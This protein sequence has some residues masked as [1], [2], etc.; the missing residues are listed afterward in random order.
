[1]D[2][3]SLEQK[4]AFLRAPDSYPERP[5]QVDAIETHMS[6]LFLTER[7]VFKLKKPI[8]YDRLDFTTLRLRRFYCEEEVRLNRRLAGTVYRGALPLTCEGDGTLA[9]DG[10]GAPVD[11]LVH[12]ERLPASRML[13]W[14]LAR[15][16]VERE[17]VRAVAVRLAQ[18]YA[19]ANRVALSATVLAGRLEEGIRADERDLCRPDFELPVERIRSIASSQLDFLR[20]HAG[21]FEDRADGGHIVDGHGDLRP[22]HICLIPEPV[23][24]DCLEFCQELRE[25][26]PADELAFL[27]L[28]CERLGQPRVGEWFFEAYEEG[29]G[30]RLPRPLL[31]FYRGYRILRRAKIAA[32]HLIDPSTRD[33]ERYAATARRYL[34][35]ARP[36]A[37]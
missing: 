31:Q 15:R 8:R 14:I 29:T 22:E 1:M 34:D 37:G 36:L 19:R 11:W 33:R 26:D 2:Q 6:W 18:F 20:E 23:I 3:P 35:L 24:I 9:V 25:Q 12:M 10:I 5:R 21:L 28:E 13:D 4:V 16:V 32:W 27:A 30:D 7:S 17:E